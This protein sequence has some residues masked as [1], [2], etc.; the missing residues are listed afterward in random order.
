MIV[1]KVNEVPETK[2]GLKERVSRAWRI[3]KGR[4]YN[5]DEVMALYKGEILEVYELKGYKTDDKEANR[6]AFDLEEKVS[7]L[8][9][10]KIKY[11]TSN[12]C[13]ITSIHEL[14]FI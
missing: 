14:E 10:R 13:T 5:Q 8:K 12:P 2:E 1:I 6:V 11:P 3:N 7:N 4:L 9:G